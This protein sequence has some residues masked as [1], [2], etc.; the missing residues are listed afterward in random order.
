MAK[1][2]PSPLTREELID[3]AYQKY[4]NDY[5]NELMVSEIPK[6]LSFVVG[7]AV[8]LGHINGLK[9][10]EIK[11][12]LVLLENTQV[13]EPSSKNNGNYST[14]EFLV[15]HWTEI[16]PVSNIKPTQFSADRPYRIHFINTDI[17]SLVSSAI[18]R[19]LNDKTDY[20]R[21]Y[22]WR[23]DDKRRLIKSIFDGKDIGKFVFVEDKTYHDPRIEVLDG[24]QRLN[25]ILGFMNDEFDYDG[26]YYHQLSEKDRRAMSGLGVQFASLDRGKFSRKE[27]LEMF[28]DVNDTGVP[29]SPEHLKHVRNLLMEEIEQ[30]SAISPR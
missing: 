18:R 5:R 27:L 24:K 7:D 11:G 25:A 16:F 21:D 17:E 13:Q 15:K 19:G 12:N 3:Q 29:Q 22:V 26:V 6:H 30:E 9:I 4:R 20:Q 2:A 8:E 10:A 28:V 23:I 1:K 14:A